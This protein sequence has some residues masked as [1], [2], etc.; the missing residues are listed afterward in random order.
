MDEKNFRLKV[1]EKASYCRHF[2]EQVIKNIK[3]KNINI[4]TY[5]SAGQEFISA[6]IA[7]ICENK[8]IKPM[9]FGQHRCH[10]IYISFGGDKI[11]LIDELLGRKT[12]CTRS[13]GGSASIHS[14]DI[15]MFG[16]DGLMGSN[17]PIGV[18]ACFAS[19][20]PTIIFLGDAAAEEDYVFGSLGWASTKNIPLLTIIEDNNLSILT[21]KKVRRNWEVDEVARSFK[22]ESYNL[23]D[24]PLNLLKYSKS[25]FKNPC[26]LNVNTHRIY[27]HAGAGKDSD[28]TFDRYEDEK[29]VL[30]NEAIKFDK[31]IEKEMEELWKKQLEKQ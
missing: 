12:G 13:M 27:W 29:K 10:S 2:E 22:I 7:T 17:G 14:K 6:T 16:H 20:K 4:P 30:G 28:D 23:D 26:L 25:F 5:V 18:G 8:K 15:N 19:K 11:K 9:I 3:K 24:N 31:K 21:E 1:F